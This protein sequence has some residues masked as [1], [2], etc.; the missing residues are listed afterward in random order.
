[1]W[2]RLRI[3]WR[4]G[5]FR[6]GETFKCAT[7]GKCTGDHS[8]FAANG[9][10]G[11]LN[12]PKNASITEIKLPLFMNCNFT[13]VII[14]QNITTLGQKSFEGCNFTKLEF[15]DTLKVLGNSSFLNCTKLA[16]PLILPNSLTT[17]G[18]NVFNGCTAFRNCSK[19][20]A[21][22]CPSK[23]IFNS[24]NAKFTYTIAKPLL[25]YEMQLKFD[26]TIMLKTFYLIVP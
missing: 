6:S 5:H 14:P 24:F 7:T 18:N 11:S 4:C 8:A 15:P 3:G 17:M 16:Q 13:S 22:I 2:K 23:E 9:F 12:L 26:G 1:M 20:T 21:I 19:L 10:D 25:C